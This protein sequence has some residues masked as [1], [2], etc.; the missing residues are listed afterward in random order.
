ME[1]M[2]PLEERQGRGR[3]PV[4]R[5]KGAHW[6]FEPDLVAEIAFSEFTDDG[7]LR[8]RS[9][10][11]LRE[12]KPRETRSCGKYRSIRRCHETVQIAEA[13]LQRRRRPTRPRRTSASKFSSPERVIFPELGLTKKDRRLSRDGRAADHGGC[14]K[15]A[16]HADPLS[17]RPHRRMLLSQHARAIS[18]HAS[19]SLIRRR[20]D[21]P[22]I[23]SISTTFAACSLP[24]RWERSIDGWG[25]KVD[26]VEYPTVGVRPTD[27]GLDFSKVKQAAVRLRG[28]LQDLGLK[29]FPSLSAAVGIHVVVSPMRPPTAG[30]GRASLIGLQ[31]RHRQAEREDVHRQH[32]QGSGARTVFLDWLRNQRGATAVMPDLGPRTRRRAGVGAGHV[33]LSRPLRQWTTSSI[34]DADELLECASSKALAAWASAGTARPLAHPLCRAPH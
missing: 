21:I 4:R 29:S 9:F 8:T 5:P 28:L 12:D 2:M 26:K 11:A 7:V 32:P 31:P 18:A 27:V 17:R 13:G 10:I 20:T 16:D 25:S 6:I 23:I 33:G 19:R 1:R 34:R 14:G 3:G 30:S 15:A 24:L 22:R